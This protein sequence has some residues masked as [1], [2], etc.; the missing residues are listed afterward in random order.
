M[1]AAA[2]GEQSLPATSRK[3]QR[4]NTTE[5]TAGA[6][7]KFKIYYPSAQTVRQ[8]RGGP[9][10]VSPDSPKPFPRTET[11]EIIVAEGPSVSNLL[12]GTMRHFHS[13]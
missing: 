13:H 8:S 5:I 10:Y 2:S 9:G 11:N 3:G 6:S 4:P 1:Y 7:S 12:I